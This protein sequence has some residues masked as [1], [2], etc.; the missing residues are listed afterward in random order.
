[1]LEQEVSRSARAASRTR[2]TRQQALSASIWPLAGAFL[3]VMTI[4][5]LGTP[6]ALVLGG[7]WVLA[8]GCG[9][10]TP[11]LSGP[12]CWAA[13]V[14]GEIG[15]LSAISLATALLSGHEHG[16]L[17]AIATLVSPIVIGAAAAALGTLLDRRR[18][19]DERATRLPGRPWV[20]WAITVAGLT[21]AAVINGK[22]PGYDVSWTM[23]G[24]GRN[25]LLQVR[26]II[27]N[28]G[29]TLHRLRAFPA[30]MHG[31][32]ALISGAGGRKQLAPGS[33]FL[34]DARS[35]ADVYLLS[36]IAIAALLVAALLELLPPLV[37]H[38]RRLPVALVPALIGCA[39]VSVS[40]LSLGTALLDGFFGTYASLPLAIATLVIALRCC[41]DPSPLA[42]ALLGPALVLTLLA[43]TVLAVAPFAVTLVVTAVILSRRDG[44][45]LVRSGRW[46][47]STAFAVTGGCLVVTLVEVASQYN[48]LKMQFL[49][50]GPA[51]TPIEH[52]VLYLVGL[53]AL[54]GLAGARSRRQA[55]PWLLAVAVVA[56]TVL[57]VQWQRSLTK[58]GDEWTYY[59]AKTLWALV[60]CLAW[61]PFAPIALAAA[62]PTEG[63]RRR[64]LS[65]VAFL[66]AAA[67]TGA[68]IIGFGFT[69]KVQDPL[70]EMKGGWVQPSASIVNA[71]VKYGDLGKPYVLWNWKYTGDDR[72]GNFMVGAIWGAKPDGTALDAEGLAGGVFLWAYT[73]VGQPHQLCVL[74][75]AVPG[76]YVVTSDKLLTPG[77]RKLC[78]NTGL[79]VI[80]T[81]M[82]Q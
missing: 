26:G 39:V 48:S 14:V 61:V 4:L 63:S 66:Q 8:F 35:I 45:Q 21:I 18:S 70:N 43:W 54:G 42:Y 12:V 30:L 27:S 82:P 33:L 71:V 69:T 1:M 75:K 80:L 52:W 24:D 20:A 17:V 53:F 79:H 23:S 49:V 38:A 60:V 68:V 59:A 13:A 16:S 34:H 58:S 37:A 40:S 19:P 55:M 36:A 2:P 5:V 9:R 47:W 77:L 50:P 44:R 15:V 28:G 11:H 31:V 25:H 32:S 57:T 10:L 6:C 41:N 73:D 76:L 62:R 56:G 67:I 51:P 46:A 7:V 29:L 72:L 3:I 74:A 81:P 22:G 64:L 78:P 65:G